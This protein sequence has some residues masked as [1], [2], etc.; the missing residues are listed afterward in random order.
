METMQ[1]I[2]LDVH[3]KTISYCIKNQNGEAFDQGVISA[4]RNSLN[5]WIGNRKTPWI[6]AMEATMFTGWIYDFLKPH[7]VDLK[8]A[9]PEISKQSQ[10]PKRKMIEKMQK[11]WRICYVLIFCQ[12]ARCFL[13]RCEN[14]VEYC[15]IE[16]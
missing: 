4:T 14:C 15:D 7:A 3:K 5:S 11:N 9:H 6:G 2:G 10:L 12:N 8:V 1:Y 13:Q 16:I